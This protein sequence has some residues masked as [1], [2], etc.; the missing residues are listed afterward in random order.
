MK[1]PRIGHVLPWPAVGGTEHATLRIARAVEREFDSVAFC[2]RGADEVM[3]LLESGGVPRTVYD[4]PVPSYRHYPRYLA[5]SLALARQ[6]R[7]QAVDLVHCADV[8]AGSHAALAGWLARIPVLCHIRNRFGDFSK[9]DASFLWP[10]RAF[11]FVSRNTWEGFGVHVPEHRGRVLYDGIALPS[12]ASGPACADRRSVCE[13][14]GLPADVPIVG[15]MARVAK[16]KDF[17]TLIRAARQVLAAQPR[18]RFLIVGDCSSEDAY[19][20]HYAELQS[21]LLAE[22]VSGAF[23]FT[24]YRRDVPRFMNALDV[25][26][27]S[28]HWEGLPLVLLEAMA[29][30]KPV[31]ATAVDGVPEA[32]D[33]GR[34]GLLVPHEDVPALAGAIGRLLD[35]GALR[36]AMGA[37][38]RTAV[39][40]RFSLDAFAA[41]LRS[42][43][44]E[45]LGR[46]APPS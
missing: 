13:E 38:G 32:I 20:Q 43:Y 27:L 24:G 45:A 46:G 37:A 10:V 21:L 22:G 40:E 36:T 12:Q 18:A 7:A 11:V 42:L 34:T 35:D 25:F 41:N 5:Q 28:T 14:F 33:H 17:P 4:P 2:V 31:I 29:H 8:A 15:T 30:A 26:V 23:V 19:R 9:R 6:F 44:T 3:A 1:K 16:Q 39:A